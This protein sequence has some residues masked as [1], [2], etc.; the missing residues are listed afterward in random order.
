[1]KRILFLILLVVSCSL[2]T[3]KAQDLYLIDS[4]TKEIKKYDDWKIA[5]KGANDPMHDTTAANIL[6]NL[7]AAYWGNNLDRK[8]VV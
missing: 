1:M 4:L 5:H 7:S 6:N 2:F 3:V 8:S